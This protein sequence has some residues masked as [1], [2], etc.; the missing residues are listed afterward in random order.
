MWKSF[1]DVLTWI[2][3]TIKTTEAFG[4]LMMFV[5]IQPESI[6]LRRVV[7]GTASLVALGTGINSASGTLE[8]R[9][10]IKPG[11]RKCEQEH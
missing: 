11:K 5:F 2:S 6:L 4:L 7:I 3:E 8:L 10:I 9:A 1:G